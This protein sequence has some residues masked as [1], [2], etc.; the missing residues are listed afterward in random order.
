M[1]SSRRVRRRGWPRRGTLSLMGGAFAVVATYCAVLATQAAASVHASPARTP[2]EP[3]ALLASASLPDGARVTNAADIPA[4]N[5]VPGYCSVGIQ[6]VYN[7]DPRGGLPSDITIDVTLPDTGWNGNYMAIGG[8]VYCAPN[9]PGT[10]QLAAGYVESTTDCGHQE[11]PL[12]SRWVTDPTGG[13]NWNRIDAFGYIA[14]HLMAVESK[15]LTADYFGIGPQ[16][17]FWNGCS[18]GG[19]QG[20]S[21]AEK[22]PTDFNGILAGA[23]ALSWPQFINAQ[24]WPQLVMEWNSDELPT[25]KEQLV[26]STLKAKCRDQNGQVDGV[27]DPR[28]CD[29]LGVLRSLIGTNTPCGMFTATDALVVQEIW[30]GPRFSGSQSNLKTGFPVW[31]GLEPGADMAGT[32]VPPPILG[33]GG[34]LGLV[35]TFQNPPGVGPWMGAPFIPTADWYQNWLYQ[36]PNWQ[37]TDETYQDFWRDFVKS[38]RLFDYALGTDNANLRTFRDH[39]GKIIMWQGLADQLIFTG[40]SINYYNHV[41]AAMGGVD[42]TEQFF[43][44]FLAPSVTHCGAPGAGS[45]APTNPMQ[46]VIDWVEHGQ[47]PAVLNASGTI[48]G[49]SVT[50]PL[51]PYPEPDAV[52]TAGDP[53]QASSYACRHTTVFDNPFQPGPAGNLGPTHS[54]NAPHRTRDHLP[55]RRT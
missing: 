25:C 32:F 43:R 33:P 19:R 17:S 23:P 24:L 46:Q 42:R 2:V 3:C 22:Y 54:W 31:F 6:A 50:R 37:F 20:L 29:V 51:C 15:A 55:A 47:A 48:N 10:T 5:G 12:T 21:E 9:S 39:G 40:D 49:Q 45:I 44:Y 28:N 35:T 7:A 14:M 4:S 1:P 8:G 26:N 34:G 11:S 41:L 52:Y 53:N 13:L 27:F 16:Y 18:T 38:G 30:Q 36:N